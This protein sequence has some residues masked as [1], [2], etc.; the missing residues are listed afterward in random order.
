MNKPHTRTCI[1]CLSEPSSPG[2]VYCDPCRDAYD[3]HALGPDSNGQMHWPSGPALA[4]D[5]NGNPIMTRADQMDIGDALAAVAED[6]PQEVSHALNQQQQTP[7]FIAID[8]KSTT[9]GAWRAVAYRASDDTG[10]PI[11]D[12]RYTAIAPGPS[13]AARA[14]RNLVKENTR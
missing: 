5:A 2:D 14:A 6:G 7:W 1:S 3:R 8:V 4:H 13:E 10:E 11:D 9:D 12:D